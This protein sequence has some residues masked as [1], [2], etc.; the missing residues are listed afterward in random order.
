MS[1]SDL[2]IAKLQRRNRIMFGSML[3]GFAVALAGLD[4]L[5]RRNTGVAKEARLDGIE[6][7]LQLVVLRDSSRRVNLVGFRLERS[8]HRRSGQQAKEC[9]PAHRRSVARC[10]V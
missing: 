2:L 8:R 7:V 9:D 4:D 10:P 5:D 1:N 3:G 6:G